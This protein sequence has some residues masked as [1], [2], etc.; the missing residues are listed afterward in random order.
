MGNVENFFKYARDRYQLM[1]DREADFEQPWSKD[2]IFQE[3]RFCNV[4]REDDRTTKWI[5]EHV[6]YEAYGDKL[7]VAMIIARWF[8]R[9]ETLE[10]LLPPKNAETP[11]FRSNLFF[12]WDVIDSWKIAMR[13]RLEG[14][15]PLVTGAYMVKTPTGMNKLDGILW[16][17]EKFI[18]E[19]CN[20]DPQ[21]VCK[22]FIDRERSL[23]A[24]T[25]WLIQAPFL[26]PFMAYEVVTDLRHTPLLDKAPD[27]MTWANPGPGAARG[28]SRILWNDKT[29][30][31]RHSPSDK[32]ALQ[33]GMQKLLKFSQ[34]AENWPKRW[35]TWEMRDVEHTLC[36]FDKYERVRL[37]EGRPK[38]K[39]RP[40]EEK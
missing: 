30:Y 21:A 26:G 34:R 33:E 31:N 8:N 20:N 35:P 9:I 37:G 11:Y 10:L 4:F 39:F 6:T 1:L 12:N 25:E 13:E 36:E 19:L 29:H 32:A 7:L 18:M 24:T 15:S 5:R 17:V 28:L 27:I 14:L 22:E 16:C 2:P 3:F 23:E 40:L 38:Q